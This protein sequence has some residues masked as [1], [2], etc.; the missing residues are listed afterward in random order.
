[1]DPPGTTIPRSRKRSRKRSRRRSRASKRAAG[2]FRAS[3]NW[4]PNLNF[5]VTPDIQRKF[6]KGVYTLREV[7]KMFSVEAYLIDK[8]NPAAKREVVD[9]KHKFL[10]APIRVVNRHGKFVVFEPTGKLPRQDIRWNAIE[11]M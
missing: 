4:R 10:D 5:D 7:M 2:K 1:M 11:T 8:K 9:D 3:L 6:N